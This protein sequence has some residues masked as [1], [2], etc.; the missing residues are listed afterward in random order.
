MFDDKKDVSILNMTTRSIPYLEALEAFGDLPSYEHKDEYG[1][2]ELT[3][4]L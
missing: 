2:E 1:C 3:I 4:E